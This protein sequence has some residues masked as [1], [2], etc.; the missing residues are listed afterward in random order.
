MELYNLF[1]VPVLRY[2][3]NESYDDIQC[4]IQEA[5]KKIKDT[6]DKSCKSFNDREGVKKT[7]DFLEK[8]ECNLLKKRIEESCIAYLQRSRWSGQYDKSKSP[9]KIE[10]SWVNFGNKNESRMQHVHPG[11]KISGV[12]YFRVS[13]EQGSIVFQNPNPMSLKWETNGELAQKDL[14]ELIERLKNVE[15]KDTSSELSRLSTKSNTIN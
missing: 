2:P 9:I 6:D 10:N 12:Y 14:S 7:Y 4:E 13:K 3:A 8:Y 1:S 11:H 5:I 15:G